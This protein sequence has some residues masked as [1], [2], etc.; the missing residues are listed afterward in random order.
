MRVR[1]NWGLFLLT[2]SAALALTA[3]QANSGSGPTNVAPPSSAA[4][5]PVAG[6]LTATQVTSRLQAQGLTVSKIKFDDGRYKVKAIDASG[7]KLKVYV[8]PQTGN[9]ISKTDDD[10]ND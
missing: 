2:G 6:P 1:T 7:R 9:V 4:P 10:D 5:A 3:C 8:D